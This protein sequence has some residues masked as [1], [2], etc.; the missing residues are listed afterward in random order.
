MTTTDFQSPTL[1]GECVAS[2]RSTGIDLE[3]LSTFERLS[4]VATLLA[5]GLSRLRKKQ[6]ITLEPLA[7]QSSPPGLEAV[8]KTCPDGFGPEM[9]MVPEA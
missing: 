7:P 9:T 2:R 1:A 8:A 6:Y 5:I 3:S 4:E